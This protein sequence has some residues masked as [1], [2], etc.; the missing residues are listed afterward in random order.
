MSKSQ[1]VAR[2]NDLK[3]GEMQAVRVEKTLVLLV[4]V[5]DRFH[6]LA[7]NCTHYGAP[8]AKGVLHGDR[9]VCPWHNACFNPSTGDQLE[10]P[11]LDDLPHF[12]V[13]VEGE[14]V[15]VTLPDDTPRHREPDMAS[16]NP[17]L[18]DRTF[19]L[20]GLGA[21]GTN[22]AETL[23]KAGFEGRIVAVTAAE[24]LP[25]DRTMLSKKY[26][27]G[28]VGENALPLR[29]E[30]F[31]RQHEIEILTGKPVE[32]VDIS[33][34][35]ITF[36]D[37]SILNYDALLLAT[38]G[39]AR[40]LN[41][42][43]ARLDNIFTLRNHQD[44]D[45]ILAAAENASRAV[46]VGSS[47]IGMETAA[48][49]AQNEVEVTVVSPESVPFEKILGDRVGKLFQKEHE[50]NGV[51][52]IFGQKASQFVGKEKVETVVLDN[53]DRLAADLAVVGIG[54]DPA[55][56]ILEGVRL[57]E[58]KS[59]TTDEYLQVAD[60]VYAAGDIATFPDWQ[61]GEPTRIEHWRLAAQHGRI[62]AYNMVGK[63]V[64][65]RGI[66]FFW[67][68]Q[69][70]LKLRYVGH[71]EQWDKIVYDGEVESGEFLAFYIKGDRVLAVSGINRDSQIAAISEL[72]RLDKMP[73]A[74]EIE[75]GS[76]DFS[77]ENGKMAMVATAKA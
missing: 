16:Y 9:L 60:G 7:A 10:P 53:G 47:F 19:V 73:S 21:A 56:D 63:E 71:A 42:E 68:G 27:Q 6:A 25:I 52:F 35:Q 61:T 54:V 69:F 1:V 4:K 55:T 34:K 62:A 72:M 29:D 31:Y 44:S 57:N 30:G 65:F 37:A 77:L 59:V 40:S 41:V 33:A 58:D 39:K 2:V 8:L 17:K 24:E 11:G 43:G 67:T 20:I 28:K 75:G 76:Y 51:K 74:A 64:P 26:L 14:E 12:Q 46:I 36:A 66:P 70:G 48:S 38:G 23:R 45:A 15:I 3:E 49:L 18:D 5:N 32:E 22:A 50:K 13:R